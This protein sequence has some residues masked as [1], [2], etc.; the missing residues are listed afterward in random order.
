MA[1]QAGRLRHTATI[2]QNIQ[3]RNKIGQLVSQWQEYTKVWCEFVPLSVNSIITAQATN[4]QIVA[5][6]VIRYRQDITSGMRLVHNGI[7]YQIDGLP[8][9]DP[10]TGRQYLTLMLKTL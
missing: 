10:K 2:L 5:R 1:L 8:L 6:C 9:P 3:S 7:T 4:N